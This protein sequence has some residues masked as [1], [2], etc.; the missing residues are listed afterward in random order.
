MVS[1]DKDIEESLYILLSTM[2]GERV[3]KPDYGCP[4]LDYVFATSDLT[5]QYLM[6]NAIKRAIVRYEPRVD[7]EDVIFEPDPNQDGVLN[8]RLLYSVRGTNTRTNIVY[9]FYILE[10]TDIIDI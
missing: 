10:G 1:D 8:V 7:L 4:L 9:P 2:P 3:T 6:K 5:G